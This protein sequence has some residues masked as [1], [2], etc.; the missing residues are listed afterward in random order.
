MIRPRNAAESGDGTIEWGNFH[1]AADAPD[2]SLPG[3]GFEARFN[4]GFVRGHNNDV[5]PLR[6]MQSFAKISGGKKMVG[7]VAAAEKQNVDVAGE[8]AVLKTI[9][10]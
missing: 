9:V 4:F 5:C 10:E 3:D 7:Q 1:A 6:C 8:L 2:N